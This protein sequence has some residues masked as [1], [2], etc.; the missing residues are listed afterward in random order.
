MNYIKWNEQLS[1]GRLDLGALLLGYQGAS[2]PER[3]VRREFVARTLGVN[4]HNDIGDP[5]VRVIIAHNLM[6]Q[7][8]HYGRL[9]AEGVNGDILR[10]AG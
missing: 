6:C 2:V 9:V 5:E 8:R 1:L 4:G 7:R 10:P 3:E